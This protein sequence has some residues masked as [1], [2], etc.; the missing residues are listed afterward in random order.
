VFYHHANLVLT[1]CILSCGKSSGET[2]EISSRLGHSITPEK[3]SLV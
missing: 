1:P 2:A 3:V